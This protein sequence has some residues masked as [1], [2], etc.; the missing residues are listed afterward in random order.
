MRIKREKY[1]DQ[2]LAQSKF[3][4][5]ISLLFFILL[6]PRNMILLKRSQPQFLHLQHREEKL[7]REA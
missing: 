6:F 1:L 4:L 2:R 3:C 7:V 5:S